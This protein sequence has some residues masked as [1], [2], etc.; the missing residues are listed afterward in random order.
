MCEGAQ[1]TKMGDMSCHG[2]S[3]YWKTLQKR[4]RQTNHIQT[5]LDTLNS[6][7]DFFLGFAFSEVNVSI[8]LIKG[9]LYYPLM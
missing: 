8:L 6:I 9:R 7:R 1:S 4:N 3:A 5:V 2:L